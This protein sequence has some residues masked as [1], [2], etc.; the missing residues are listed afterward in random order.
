MNSL[1]RTR[2]RSCDRDRPRCPGDAV[3][4]IALAFDE[5]AAAKEFERTALREALLA[6]AYGGHIAK[7][8]AEE[9][10]RRSNGSPFALGVRALALAHVYDLTVDKGDA[11]R[12]SEASHA[13]ELVQAIT[14][15]RL[16]TDI[17]R[18]GIA[19]QARA[20]ALEEAVAVAKDVEEKMEKE[21]ANAPK[22]QERDEYMTQR[23]HGV[24]EV[25]DALET[26]AAGPETNH[27]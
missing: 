1:P 24:T 6:Y 12:A 9:L 15:D 26:L 27:G 25:I 17:L 10:G 18:E 7:E 16:T 20:K 5:V 22:D 2:C 19:A 21:L 4:A 14:E 11:E 23:L 8:I 13:K 3:R